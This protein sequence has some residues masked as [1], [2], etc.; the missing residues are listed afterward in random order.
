MRLSVVAHDHTIN[1]PIASGNIRDST[2]PHVEFT[3]QIAKMTV[4]PDPKG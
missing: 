4:R 3:I 2:P 1:E